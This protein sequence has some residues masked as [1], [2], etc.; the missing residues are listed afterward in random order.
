MTH[1]KETLDCMRDVVTHTALA[2]DILTS[3]YGKHSAMDVPK[4]LTVQCNPTGAKFTTQLRPRKAFAKYFAEGEGL[5]LGHCFTA[6]QRRND[7]SELS[8]LPGHLLEPDLTVLSP[9]KAYVPLVWLL[10][11]VQPHRQKIDEGKALMKQ[12]TY[13]ERPF[14]LF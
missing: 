2:V 12:G 11:E 14:L 4:G 13:S 1:L 7:T 6:G 3:P 10:E 5:L 9:T 8:T